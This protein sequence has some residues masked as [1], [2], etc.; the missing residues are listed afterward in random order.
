[1][2]L[3]LML[4]CVA[5]KVNENEAVCEETTAITCEDKIISD[6]SLHD[7]QGAGYTG[8]VATIVE[9]ED[10][11]TTIDASAG[12]MNDSGNNPWVYV[13]FTVDGAEQEPEIEAQ[14]TGAENQETLPSGNEL[15]AEIDPAKDPPEASESENPIE[16]EDAAPIEGKPEKKEEASE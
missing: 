14:E 1:M 10:F 11:V 12:G 13:K 3:T 4:A 5:E 2:L 9:G 7:D 16:E 6:L 8:S 15:P